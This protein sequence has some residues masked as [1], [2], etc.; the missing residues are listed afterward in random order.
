MAGTQAEHDVEATDDDALSLVRSSPRAAELIVRA[1]T[2]TASELELA[3][4][5]EAILDQTVEMLG[6]CVAHLCSVVGEGDEVRLEGER[7]VPAELR[8]R[9]SQCTFHD[10]F[11]A[12]R[13]GASRKIQLVPD[14]DAMDPSLDLD[15]ELMTR[16]ECRSMV[17]IPLIASGRLVG[18]LTYALRE[19]HEFSAADVA[20]L[21]VIANILAT[22]VAKANV[23]E[24]ERMLRKQLEG[25]RNATLAISRRYELPDVLQCI[26]DEARSVAGARYAALGISRNDPDAP[27]DPWVYSGMT[28]EQAAAIGRDL[29]RVHLARELRED[30]RLISRA[31]ADLEHALVA[32]QF[33][34]RRHDRDD[35]R[36]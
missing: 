19:T 33:E 11:L 34:R 6:A 22:G 23:Y 25:I 26:V 20:A 12:G 13:A 4:M 5:V 8:A 31:G 14:V 9:L 27:F 7:N 24:N 36:L 29:D 21:R 3:R 2:I 1:A 30:R 35:E 16:T 10:G 17:A 28:A 18:V 15:H 32:L